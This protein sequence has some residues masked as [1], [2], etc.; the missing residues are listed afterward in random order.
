MEITFCPSCGSERIKKI[1]AT[2]TREFEGTTYSVP[3]VT[4]YVCPDCGE[5]LYDGEA[6]RKIQAESPAFRERVSR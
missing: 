2:V 4:Y 5:E 1:T 6:V 3:D